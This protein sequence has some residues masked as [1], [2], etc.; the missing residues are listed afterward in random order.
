[1]ERAQRV[2]SAI[3]LNIAR[4]VAWPRESFNGHQDEIMLCLYR[5]NPFGNGL[6][7]IRGKR[8]GSRKLG[9]RI[10]S[11]D[12]TDSGCNVLFIPSERLSQYAAE[13]TA[14]ASRH[15]LTITDRT[16]YPMPTT[17]PSVS[18]AL[19]RDQKRIGFEVDLSVV[20]RAGLRMSSELLKLA[21]IVGRE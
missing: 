3:I 1:L 8:V 6:K 14:T 2:K 11:P 7:G 4:F 18:V 10:L 19:F 9:I 20:K 16:L 12:D 13:S 5:D 15:L 21:R 17:S